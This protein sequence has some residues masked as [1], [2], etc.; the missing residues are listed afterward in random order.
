MNNQ[1]FRITTINLHYLAAEHNEHSLP[2]LTVDTS[3]A[4]L[5]RKREFNCQKSYC[6]K[7]AR[8]CCCAKF[9]SINK[10]NKVNYLLTGAEARL[11]TCLCMCDVAENRKKLSLLNSSTMQSIIISSTEKIVVFLSNFVHKMSWTNFRR[12]VLLLNVFRAKLQLSTLFSVVDIVHV[13]PAMQNNEEKL[14]EISPSYRHTSHKL[15]HFAGCVVERFLQKSE[16]PLHC[17][18]RWL[19]ALHANVTGE[20]LKVKEMCD[21]LSR[22]YVFLRHQTQQNARTNLRNSFYVN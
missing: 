2:M 17:L 10:K 4:R 8:R 15:H 13:R 14:K 11:I 18:W 16:R 6:W 3:S 12:V 5:R 20:R 21:N 1:M 7:R 19:M 22:S 9:M